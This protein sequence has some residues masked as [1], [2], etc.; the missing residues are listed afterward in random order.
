MFEEFNISYIFTVRFMKEIID[1][2]IN[3]LF[4][5]TDVAI[6]IGYSKSSAEHISRLL[7]NVDN[8]GITKRELIVTSKNGVK[9]KR[10]ITCLTLEGLYEF[11][12]KSRKPLAK[13]FKK[14]VEQ[15][16]VPSF[17][18]D[19]TLTHA[20]TTT[21]VGDQTASN[22]ASSR[23]SQ[24]QV[25]K[26]TKKQSKKKAK[27]KT[28]S[29]NQAADSS[30]EKPKT[31][32]RKKPKPITAE[33]REREHQNYVEFKRE[34]DERQERERQKKNNRNGIVTEDTPLNSDTRIRKELNDLAKD[35]SAPKSV[36]FKKWL[37]GKVI[38]RII[39]I[40]VYRMDYDG[41][42]DLSRQYED[43]SNSSHRL[44]ITPQG[45]KYIES[46]HPFGKKTQLPMAA[47]YV[48]EDVISFY[49]YS[50]EELPSIMNTIM[51]DC[52]PHWIKK[53]SVF[54]EP[55]SYTGLLR[56]GDTLC[57]SEEAFYYFM[58]NTK[59]PNAKQFNDWIDYEVLFKLRRDDVYSK[60]N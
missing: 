11:L 2:A 4:V 20:S 44:R 52:D 30:T 22:N 43:D 31:K 5:A 24:S 49:G 23:T 33:E 27:P 6:A 41:K 15:T 48:A 1:G 14:Y 38:P 9:S 57:F 50:K 34:W 7:R 29:K 54:N 58:L 53:L 60:N 40:Q 32:S 18:E 28:K 39:Q 35:P 19:E 45:I 47:W 16:I 26:Q 8:K 36:A 21:Q 59:Q 42:Y 55:Q 46:C 12:A 25:K 3:G 56:N 37:A 10:Y 51:K 13:K 17:S